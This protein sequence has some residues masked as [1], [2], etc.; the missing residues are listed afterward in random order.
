MYVTST[1]NTNKG[2]AIIQY[3]T[4]NYS[5]SLIY[6]GGELKNGKGEIV[7]KVGDES[8]NMG[9]YRIEVLSEEELQDKKNISYLWS[10]DNE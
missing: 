7:F 4:K 3:L 5:S 6:K 10:F 9:D 1:K 2:E 8:A